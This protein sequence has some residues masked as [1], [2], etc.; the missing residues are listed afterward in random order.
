M[1]KLVKYSLCTNSPRS[2]RR[3]I[4]VL[5]A[6]RLNRGMVEPILNLLVHT[7]LALALGDS[8]DSDRYGVRQRAQATLH[9][10]PTTA[11]IGV[12]LVARR[13]PECH[14]Q[15]ERWFAVKHAP[16]TPTDYGVLCYGDWDV[17]L[18]LFRA[19]Q[20]RYTTMLR[21]NGIVQPNE[22][23]AFE[24]LPVYPREHPAALKSIR[25]RLGVLPSEGQP[26]AGVDCIYR[27]CP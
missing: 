17:A 24:N 20:S 3:L 21:A 9:Q 1:S 27:R 12:Q 15:A 18:L 13:S 11:A 10:L 25:Q 16:T 4:V 2:L 26:N 6:I 8:L 23:F 14:Y 7:L 5:P 19:Q 22:Y